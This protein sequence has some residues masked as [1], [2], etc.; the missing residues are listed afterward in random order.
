MEKKN[1]KYVGGWSANNGSSYGHGYYYDN[2]RQAR[3]DLRAIAAG[4]TFAGSS[5]SWSV[6]LSADNDDGEPV[7]SGRV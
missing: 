7:A 2:L 5:G 1:K 3:H 6:Y 4:N